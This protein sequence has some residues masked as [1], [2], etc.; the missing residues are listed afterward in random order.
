MI[1][2]DTTVLVYATGSDHPLRGPSRAV[3][4][5]LA[6]GTLRAT[7]TAEVLQEFA[8]VRA[9]RTDHDRASR[10][11]TEFLALLSPLITVTESDLE[12]GLDLW[13]V[14]P[15]LGAFDAVLA[16]SAR[17]HR[18]TLLSA[19]KAFAAVPGLDHSPLDDTVVA[20]LTDA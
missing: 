17:S 5:A 20:R 3:V 7:T 6:D 12:L 13:R 8:H 10:L 4:A 16:A 19:D 9:R 2:L 15:T 18:A 14:T 11:T 1:I